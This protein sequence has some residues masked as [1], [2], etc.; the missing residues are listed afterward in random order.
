MPL[1]RRPSD[2][3]VPPNRPDEETARAR[4]RSADPDERW[5]AA[6]VLAAFPTAVGA[7]G[8]AASLE[9]ETRVREA[10]FTS[11]ALIGAAESVT[12]LIPHLRSDH[13]ERRTG[14]MDALKAM[15]QALGPA[16]PRLLNDADPDVRVLACDL[17]RVLSSADATALLSQVLD[18]ERDVNVCAAAVDVIAD[19]G[20]PD[21]LPALTGCGRRLKDPF[22][23]FA[24]EVACRR[25]GEQAPDRG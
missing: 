7:L 5:R 25:I 3:T 11:L 14:A 17:T 10:I 21:A 19:V 4:L 22:L 23:A 2:S 12:A 18:K 13:A 24:I 20:S 1:V 9:T 15:P 8:E 16:L 6:R